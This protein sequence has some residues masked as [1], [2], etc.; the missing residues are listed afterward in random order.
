MLQLH[1]TAMINAAMQKMHGHENVKVL[2]V[3]DF[4]STRQID[5]QLGVPGRALHISQTMMS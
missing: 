5:V 2:I 4:T 1:N 3:N